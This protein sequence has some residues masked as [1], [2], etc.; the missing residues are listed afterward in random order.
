MKT[1][2]DE[3][4]EELRTSVKDPQNKHNF[5]GRSNYD[6]LNNHIYIEKFSYIPI[7]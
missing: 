1:L 7:E 3:F 6:I 5:T 2:E 4:L